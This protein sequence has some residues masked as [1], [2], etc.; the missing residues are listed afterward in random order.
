MEE[1]SLVSARI[2]GTRTVIEGIVARRSDGTRV[3]LKEDGR[4]TRLSNCEHIVL[5]EGDM[6]MTS[7]KTSVKT[8]SS[9]SG[10]KGDSSP[11][12][13]IDSILSKINPKKISDKNEDKM[14]DAVGNAAEV[15]HSKDLKKGEGKPKAATQWTLKK[16]VDGTGS[17]AQ[18]VEK[19][20]ADLK[21]YESLERE[22]GGHVSDDLWNED[23]VPQNE[24]W[25]DR[26][27]E[28]IEEIED[29]FDPEVLMDAREMTEV[30]TGAPDVV[31]PDFC[32]IGPEVYEEAV[33]DAVMML[34]SAVDD[35]V[36][37]LIHNYEIGEDEAERILK[38]AL[39]RKCPTV[40]ECEDEVEQAFDE[41]LDECPDPSKPLD[42]LCEKFD[43]PEDVAMRIVER[44]KSTVDSV[45]GLVDYVRER[46]R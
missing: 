16:E 27:E 25:Y 26:P 2:R 11:D 23:G 24:Y 43:I 34:E 37:C 7:S 46:L 33:N 36:T 6:M 35:V 21:I 44:S 42:Y 18:K 30:Q 19:A 13:T 1:G 17:N 3:I 15:I 5:R 8:S 9:S 40:L 12:K 45:M 10:S 22:L 38:D 39:D 41:A 28:R 4:W 31:D 14:L 29:L 20:M 32:S